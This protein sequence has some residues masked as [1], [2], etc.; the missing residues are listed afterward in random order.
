MIIKY[1]DQDRIMYVVVRGSDPD[2]IAEIANA[3]VATYVDVRQGAARRRTP[4]R[5]RRPCRSSSIK[6]RSKLRESESALFQFQ[7]D[8]ELL[9]VTLEERQN[10]CR[11]EHHRVH[12]KLNDA[13]IKRIELG[14]KLE[15][16]KK[17]SAHDVLDVA[18]PDDGRQVRPF[19]RCARSTTRSAT[20]SSSSRRKSGRRTPST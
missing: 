8:N 2:A 7:K 19:D 11:R 10:L 15:R 9:A 6:P 12:A 5:P 1:P 4:R 20:S 3:H 14:S 17:A 16:M 18:D 13:R